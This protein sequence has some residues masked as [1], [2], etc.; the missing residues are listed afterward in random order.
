L[1][2]TTSA[3]DM[4]PL[5]TQV[6]PTKVPPLAEPLHWVMAALTVVAG[7][8]LQPVVMPS[9][10]PTHW[11]TVTADDPGLTPM[12][13]LVMV[14]LQR[15]TA[16]PPLAEPLHCVTEVTGSLRLV[17]VVVHA[18]PRAPSVGSPAEPRHSWTVTV[19]EPPVLVMLLTIVTWQMMPSPPTLP[20]PVTQA[21]VALKEAAAT[22]AGVTKATAGNSSAN[23]A[24]PRRSSVGKRLRWTWFGS[25][26]ISFS[27][28]KDLGIRGNN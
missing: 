3:E 22:W 24:I 25:V 13:L 2:V 7:K 4:V 10:E 12:K 6:I 20:I 8:G 18:C 27:P 14:T 5:A 21:P 11:L 9:P 15:R 16:P 23:M 17:V 28:E 1:I 26:L 19:A